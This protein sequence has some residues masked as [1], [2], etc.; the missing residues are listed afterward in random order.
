MRGSSLDVS[1]VDHAVAQR[2]L[3]EHGLR[4][5]ARHLVAIGLAQA[6][7]RREL[8]QRPVL[9]D[10]ADGGGLAGQD[11]GRGLDNAIEDGGDLERGG[12]VADAVIEAAELVLAPAQALRD[13]HARV[14][15]HVAGRREEQQHGA[16]VQ[17]LAVAHRLDDGDVREHPG[18]LE[19]RHEAH[20]RRRERHVEE[21]VM[22]RQEQRR[23]RDVD[24]E[25]DDRRALGAA[26]TGDEHGHREPV[27]HDLRPGERLE[28]PHR[29]RPG[30]EQPAED[31][32]EPHVVEQ[33]AAADQIQARRRERH[34]QGERR[35]GRR[36]EHAR[37]GQP[38]QRDQPAEAVDELLLDE[39]PPPALDGRPGGFEKRRHRLFRCGG[40]SRP[41]S[42]TSRRLPACG[43]STP[44]LR[45]S[46]ACRRTCRPAAT[47]RRGRGP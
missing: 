31:Q 44:G 5:L 14:G 17:R 12:D 7:A 2:V 38:P 15:H 6:P 24:E 3:V 18:V 37:A 40:D 13:R 30:P 28:L 33:D 23:D 42:G 26:R 45:A 22:V 41:T 20:Q 8:D 10:Q 46:P 29:L 9:V 11:A 19:E 32:P 34:A 43:P 21:T 4:V 39:R 35:H 47:A 36:D 16:H 25:E 1:H 27:Q